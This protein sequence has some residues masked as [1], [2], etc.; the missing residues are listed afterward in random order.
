[1]L[2]M[3]AARNVLHSDFFLTE[4]NGCKY[5]ACGGNQIMSYRNKL[6]SAAN[7]YNS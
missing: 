1:M 3:K 6:V 2:N 7:G 4:T 5:L